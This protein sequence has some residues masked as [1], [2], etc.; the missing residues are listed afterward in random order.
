MKD[1]QTKGINLDRICKETRIKAEAFYRKYN[2]IP[3]QKKDCCVFDHKEEEVSYTIF[4]N[5]ASNLY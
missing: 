2:I 4:S 5:R 1:T 3:V